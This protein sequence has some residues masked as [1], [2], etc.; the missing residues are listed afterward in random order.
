MEPCFSTPSAY[1]DWVNVN[2]GFNP[3]GAKQSDYL[4]E[5]IFKDLLAISACCPM[6]EALARS[7]PASCYCHGTFLD[8]QRLDY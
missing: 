4:A 1:M 7:C 5:C 3:R 2:L 8:Y 6:L